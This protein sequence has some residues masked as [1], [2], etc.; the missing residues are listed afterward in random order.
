MSRI[1]I[2]LRENQ[3]GLTE[4]NGELEQPTRVNNLNKFRQ[5]PQCQVLLATI[6]SSGDGIDLRCAQ[7]VYIMVSLNLFESKDAKCDRTD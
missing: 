7:K 6:R 3:I 5:D 2:A 1:S 4:L